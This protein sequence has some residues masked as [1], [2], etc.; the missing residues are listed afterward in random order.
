MLQDKNLRL[1]KICGPM[2]PHSSLF[3]KIRSGVFN[4]TD[5]HTGRQTD[6][7]INKR[8]VLHNVLGGRN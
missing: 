1:P 6:R 3:V 8:R 4:V 2:R 7:Q 5:K